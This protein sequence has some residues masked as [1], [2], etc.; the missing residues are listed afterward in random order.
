MIPPDERTR[1]LALARAAIAARLGARPDVPGMRTASPRVPG[2]FV[3]IRQS[4]ELR[5][6]VGDPTAGQPLDEVVASCAASSAFE[7]P[8]FPPLQASELPGVV[9]EISVLGPLEPIA[10]PDDIE[11]GRHGLVVEQGSRRG[12]LL[13]QVAVECEWDRET[14]LVQ[15][16]RKAGLPAEAWRRAVVYRF[17]AEVFGENDE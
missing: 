14:F 4:G 2:A 9:L 8:R 17:E 15:T 10:S 6:C 5:G 16:A 12:L 13:P 11:I 3:T 1:L 7:D